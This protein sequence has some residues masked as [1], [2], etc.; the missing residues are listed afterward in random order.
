M[1]LPKGVRSQGKKFRGHWDGKYGPS[2]ITVAAAKADRDLLR[3]GI[4]LS[5]PPRPLPPTFWGEGARAMA[6][7]RAPRAQRALGAVRVADKLGVGVALAAAAGYWLLGAP[8]T[9]AGEAQGSRPPPAAAETSLEGRQEG[10]EG[11]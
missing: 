9:G 1:P 10:P 8:G 2:R 4:Q 11:S 7:G 3:A 6:G 5:P